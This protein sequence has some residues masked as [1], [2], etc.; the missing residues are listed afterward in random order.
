MVI[1]GLVLLCPLPPSSHGYTLSCGR[2]RGGYGPTGSGTVVPPHVLS[3]RLY[4]F[5]RRLYS[6][7]GQWAG[8]YGPTGSGAVV[9]PPY[10][11]ILLYALVKRWSEGYGPTESSTVVPFPSLL[12]LLYSLVLTVEGRVGSLGAWYC[13]APSLPLDTAV[14]SR[15]DGGVG[16]RVLRDLVLLCPLP[17]SRYCCILLWVLAY[18]S[19]LRYNP[20]VCV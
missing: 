20:S 7:V 14:P 5:V 4:C 19:I 2:W 18:V 3:I 10:P 8:G 15:S 11:L 17:P 1:R 6:V 16:G 12:I 13:C 9:P